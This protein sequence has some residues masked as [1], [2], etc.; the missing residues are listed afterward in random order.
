MC[1]MSSNLW[2]L[3]RASETSVRSTARGALGEI[4]LFTPRSLE[5][6]SSI[7]LCLD[8]IPPFFN[9]GLLL[10]GRSSFLLAAKRKDSQPKVAMLLLCTRHVAIV[11]RTSAAKHNT[12]MVPEH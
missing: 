9:L 4:W 8:T 3:L 7:V 5:G 10:G 11:M 6:Q 2:T 1:W 12:L